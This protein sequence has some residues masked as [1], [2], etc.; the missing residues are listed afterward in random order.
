MLFRSILQIKP[1]TN[2]AM[3]SGFDL[4]LCKACYEKELRQAELA[5]GP[6]G[7]EVR[8]VQGWQRR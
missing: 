5:A 7:D 4:P 6:D 3:A 1:H 2:N 8:H